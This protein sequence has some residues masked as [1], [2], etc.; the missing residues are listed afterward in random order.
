MC[1]Q[2]SNSS[3]DDFWMTGE[4]KIVVCTEV[5]DGT[6]A[7]SN[8]HRNILGS[9]DHFLSLPG[10]SLGIKTYLLSTD[11]WR[12]FLVVIIKNKTKQFEYFILEH[13]YLPQRIQI[14]TNVCLELPFIYKAYMKTFVTEQGYVTW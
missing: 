3:L 8:I 4:P 1:L 13:L 6:L 5:K 14:Q 12:I 7:A 10:A 2:S 9:G 11:F